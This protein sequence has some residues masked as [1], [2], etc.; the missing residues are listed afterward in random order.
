MKIVGFKKKGG[1]KM[2]APMVDKK[3]EAINV[4]LE[5]AK[6]MWE[7][8]TNPSREKIEREKREK[9]LLARLRG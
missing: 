1:K 2:A 7:G 3:V 4:D 9:E 5:T 8:I 6:K